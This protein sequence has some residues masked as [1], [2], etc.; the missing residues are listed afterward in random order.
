MGEIQRDVRERESEKERANK[1]WMINELGRI[2]FLFISLMRRYE[3][4]RERVVE[5]KIK[6]RILNKHPDCF[7]FNQPDILLLSL[8]NISL[9]LHSHSVI[10]HSHSFK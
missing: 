8:T 7:P 1:K 2:S 5:E 4:E 10:L 6:E 3:K 9:F